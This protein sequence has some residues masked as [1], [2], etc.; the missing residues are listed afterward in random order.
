MVYSSELLGWDKKRFDLKS[1]GYAV[2]AVPTLKVVGQFVAFDG[3]G[4]FQ[5]SGAVRTVDR[6]HFVVHD[7]LAGLTVNWRLRL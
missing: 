2:Q 1:C 6:R 5:G 3:D 4:D 7:Q